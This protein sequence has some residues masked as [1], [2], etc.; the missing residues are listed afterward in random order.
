MT[1]SSSLMSNC[2]SL[3]KSEIFLYMKLSAGSELTDTQQLQ[4]GSQE[5][6]RMR[7]G[8]SQLLVISSSEMTG[9]RNVS[10]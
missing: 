3:K 5:E 4:H 1:D 10:E 7:R 8:R 9:S 2:N 6:E